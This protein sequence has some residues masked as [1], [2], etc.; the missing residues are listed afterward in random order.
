MPTE[1][2]ATGLRNGYDAYVLAHTAQTSAKTVLLLQGKPVLPLND[3]AADAENVFVYRCPA[4]RVP[5][6]SG[7]AWTPGAKIYWDDTAKNF[8]TAPAAGANTVSGLIAESA[9]S[10]DTEGV[11][12]LDPAIPA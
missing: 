3:A 1:I 5:K 7:E 9:E 8:T 10:A 4:I 6:A 11:I 2:L 12:D